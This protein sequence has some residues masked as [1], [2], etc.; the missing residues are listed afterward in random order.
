[1]DEKTMRRV[2]KGFIWN[3][4]MSLEAF[5]MINDYPRFDDHACKQFKEITMNYAN[6]KFDKR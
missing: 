6:E 3:P 4:D 5:C 1:M 2:T